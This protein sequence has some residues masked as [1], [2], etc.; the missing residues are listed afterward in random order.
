M[1]RESQ[2]DRNDSLAFRAARYVGMQDKPRTSITV[3]PGEA[4]MVI[5]DDGYVLLYS[6]VNGYTNGSWL[7][8]TPTR[9]RKILA[10]IERTNL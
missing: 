10:A 6:E 3:R 1:D 9:K 4:V 2:T 5:W 7:K 8:L